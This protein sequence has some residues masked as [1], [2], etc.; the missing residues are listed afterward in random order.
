MIYASLAEGQGGA[1][2]HASYMYSYTALY[3]HTAPAAHIPM[4]SYSDKLVVSQK[5]SDAL[6]NA[7]LARLTRE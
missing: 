5:C 4:R 1:I 3:V 2:Q 7:V 6:Q